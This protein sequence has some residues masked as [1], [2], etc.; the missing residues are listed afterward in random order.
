MLGLKVSSA[1]IG[2]IQK[3]L[4]IFSLK[5]MTSDREGSPLFSD[6]ELTEDFV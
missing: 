5:G 1:S 3:L 4:K 6:A 2:P